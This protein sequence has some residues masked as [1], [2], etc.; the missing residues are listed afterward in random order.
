MAPP[1]LCVVLFLCTA[2]APVHTD[3]EFIDSTSL[4][5]GRTDHFDY[6]ASVHGMMVAGHHAGVVDAVDAALQ[7]G[8][9]DKC[10]PGI[11]LST[12]SFMK[13]IALYHIG[14]IRLAQEAFVASVLAGTIQGL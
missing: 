10:P 13:G 8:L 6:Y 7:A 12:L 14:H 1:W 3:A 5:K 11:P 9:P 4:S 2:C